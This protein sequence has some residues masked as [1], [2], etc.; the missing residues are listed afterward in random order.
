MLL[1]SGKHVPKNMNS[2]SNFPLPDPLSHLSSQSQTPFPLHS[3]DT[4]WAAHLQTETAGHH[5]LSF[6]DLEEC[7]KSWLS[8]PGLETEAL[9]SFNHLENNILLKQLVMTCEK[10]ERVPLKENLAKKKSL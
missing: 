3:G 9:T 7:K 5:T 2:R 8:L 4:Q 10:Q 1:T 6:R